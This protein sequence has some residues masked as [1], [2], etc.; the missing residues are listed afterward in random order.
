[1]ICINWETAGLVLKIKMKFYRYEESNWWMESSSRWLWTETQGPNN[2]PT[3]MTNCSH[4]RMLIDNRW[5]LVKVKITLNSL[6]LISGACKKGYSITPRSLVYSTTLFHVL[7]SLFAC[8]ESMWN[9]TIHL[10][11]WACLDVLILDACPHT[12]VWKTVLLDNNCGP[13]HHPV[14]HVQNISH[15]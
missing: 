2:Y 10:D 9:T 12:A 11:Y 6:L 3:W 5:K 8:Q 4:M 15:P 13:R 1:M 7:F 14:A